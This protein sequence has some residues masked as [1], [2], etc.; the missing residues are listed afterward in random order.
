MY[1]ND[2]TIMRMLPLVLSSMREHGLYE[3][4]KKFHEMVAA[5]SFPMKNIAYL[6]FLDVVR[7]YSSESTTTMRYD[8][9]VSRFWRTGYKLFHGRFLRFISGPKNRGE[10][11]INDSKRGC[12]NPAES[13]INFA[14][15][16]QKVKKKMEGPMPPDDIKPGILQ[17]MIHLIA[18]QSS[19]LKTY[20][21]CL[22]G[23]KINGSTTGILGDVDLFGHEQK[24][25]LREKQNRLQDEILH[26]ESVLKTLDNVDTNFL[27]QSFLP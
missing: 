4:W 14:V 24:L 7:W 1:N 10:I 20:K 17:H 2:D 9:V 21:L 25:T 6:L 19:T 16:I 11:I 5:G 18:E 27:L 23:K 3:V 8:D 13:E 15:P 12:F 26:T 22:D